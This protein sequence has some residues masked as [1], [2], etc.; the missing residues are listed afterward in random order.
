MYASQIYLRLQY[1][2]RIIPVGSLVD[3]LRNL[4]FSYN[5]LCVANVFSELCISFFLYANE[6]Y[7][8]NLQ[9]LC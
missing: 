8:I 9:W 7:G 3:I 1:F 2:R 6:L 5:I 4:I